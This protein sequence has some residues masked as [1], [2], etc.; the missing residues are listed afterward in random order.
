MGVLARLSSCQ[1]VKISDVAREAGVSPST[2]SHVLNRKR[3]ISAETS[4]RVLEAIERL[5]YQPNPAARALRGVRQGIIGLIASDLTDVLVTRIV[6]GVEKAARE[7]EYHIIFA[8]AAD[9]GDDL[10]EAA[11]F[12]TR[13]RVDG[14]LVSSAV[15]QRYDGAVLARLEVPLVTINTRLQTGAASVLPDNSRGGQDAARHL[16]ERGATHPGMI[17]GPEDRVASEDRLRGFLA[18]CAQAGNAPVARPRIHHGD[19]TAAA[20]AAG[21][22]ALLRLD[23][24]LD[25]VFCAND[26]IAAGAMNEARRLGLDVPARLRVLGFDNRD[27]CA[28]WPIPLSTFAQPFEEMGQVAMGIL[29]ELVEGRVPENPD[30]LLR[31]PLIR[32][33]ST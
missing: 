24:D 7:R 2:V 22:R 27:Y 31:A 1:M 33:A 10:R 21:L 19:F 26:E 23:P 28:F 20:G 13:R 14:L 6:R 16:L 15:Y 12:L 18:G 3:S 25:G 5:G 32:R 8:S 17:A 30:P 11:K 9:F 29:A 4:A